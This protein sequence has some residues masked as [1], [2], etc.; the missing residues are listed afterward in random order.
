MKIALCGASG[1]GKTTLAK[2]LAEIT[3]LPFDKHPHPNGDGSY[4][5]LTRA[6]AWEYTGV[7]LPYEVDKAGMREA[8]QYEGG[9]RKFAWEA[10]MADKEGGFVTDRTHLDWLAYAIL[11]D[12]DK[13]GSNEH[14]FNMCMERTRNYDVILFCTMERFHKVSNDP[15]RKSSKLYHQL[16]EMVLGSLIAEMSLKYPDGPIILEP[17]P[18]DDVRSILACAEELV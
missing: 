10:K 13:S 2:Q 14:Y 17:Q 15:A 1:T 5:S 7:D 8:F 3:K 4:T 16:Y 6:L 12:I 11:H 9:R 18:G